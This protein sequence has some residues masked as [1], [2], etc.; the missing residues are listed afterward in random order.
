MNFKKQI[1]VAGVLAGIACS[2]Y[3]QFGGGMGGTG[4]MGGM[5]RGG[6]GG[7]QSERPAENASRAA[8]SMEQINSRLYDLRL[9]LLITP[10]QS[11]AWEG[12]RNKFIDL[13]TARPR[14][15][16]ALEMQTAQLAM[17]YQLGM[18]QDR[19]TLTEMLYEAHKTLFA[20]LTPDQQHAADQAIPPLLAELGAGSGGGPS[21]RIN[22]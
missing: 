14:S 15:P 19:F 11:A 12:F 6:G 8:P 2:T 1:M 4:G 7:G 17:Q 3:A 5:R 13:A 21:S 16:S 9:R 18:A 22:R 10:G 20:S